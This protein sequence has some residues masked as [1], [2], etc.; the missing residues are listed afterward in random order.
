MHKGEKN[1]QFHWKSETMKFTTKFSV[2]LALLFLF[3]DWATGLTDYNDQVL[4]LH[5]HP[6]GKRAVLLGSDASEPCRIY[7]HEYILMVSNILIY[8]FQLIISG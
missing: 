4:V 2:F 3:Q 7:G 5:N 1:F 6:R 8:Y